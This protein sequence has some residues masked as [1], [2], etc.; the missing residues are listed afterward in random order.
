MLVSDNS[1]NQGLGFE[2]LKRLIEIG[3]AEK[4]TRLG[5]QILA[6]NHAMQHICKK[7]GFKIVADDDNRG[8]SA[9]FTF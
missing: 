9:Q 3:R 1:Q 7:L 4:L 2:L 6:E 5:G 8:C